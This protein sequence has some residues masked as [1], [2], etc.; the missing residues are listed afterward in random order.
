VYQLTCAFSRLLFLVHKLQFGFCFRLSKQAVI[1]LGN[2]EDPTLPPF[3]IHFAHMMGC[4]I[5][6]ER[7]NS[8]SLAHA[9]VTHLNL[10]LK[11]LSAMKE[12][13]DPVSLAQAY[14]CLAL[15]CLYT[16]IPQSAMTFV[17]KALG[18][19]ERHD[20]R[21]VSTKTC[22]SDRA[23]DG[24]LILT[25]DIA[26]V[27]VLLAQLLYSEVNRLLVYGKSENRCLHIEKQF[28]EEVEVRR[29]RLNR[30]VINS[31]C[32]RSPT[33]YCWKY[34]LSRCVLRVYCSSRTLGLSWLPVKNPV[35]CVAA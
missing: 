5:F 21:C 8:F 29:S 11:S 32:C 4:Y 14:H 19:V 9:Q 24:S 18:V 28:R 33:R 12:D 31:P 22:P 2:L 34:A 15:A 17:E 10:C 35:R 13:D 16:H 1:H 3:F 26:E 25:E 6:Q 30:L 7:R 23:P 20:I 27:V